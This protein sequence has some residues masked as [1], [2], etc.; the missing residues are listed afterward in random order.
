MRLKVF[1]PSVLILRAV[2]TRAKSVALKVTIPSALRGMFIATK[3]W[4]GE[5]Q[6]DISKAKAA[7]S[8]QASA[9]QYLTNMILLGKKVDERETITAAQ[10]LI[11]DCALMIITWFHSGI[12]NEAIMLAYTPITIINHNNNHNPITNNTLPL[13]HTAHQIWE[14]RQPLYLSR[15]FAV[16]FFVY[17]HEIS[18]V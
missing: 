2:R 18:F 6:L 16:I 11:S 1:S 9:A 17:V 10:K 7:I 12:P 14:R 4:Q 3:R 13:T 8:A 5:D 15:K